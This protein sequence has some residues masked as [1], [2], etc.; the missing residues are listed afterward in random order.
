MLVCAALGPVCLLSNRSRT[1]D[2]A[3]I[4]GSKCIGPPNRSGRR[5]LDEKPPSPVRFWEQNRSGEAQACAARLRER[6]SNTL[7]ELRKRSRPGRLSHWML[8]C[9]PGCRGLKPRRLSKEGLSRAS[10]RPASPTSV[11]ATLTWT[12]TDDASCLKPGTTTA[13]S[14]PS[15]KFFGVR[16]SG[17]TD[18]Y[19]IPIGAFAAELAYRLTQTGV[20]Y[21]AEPIDYPAIAVGY[22]AQ[23]YGTA[24]TNSVT[25]EE[26]Q[27]ETALISFWHDCPGHKVILA[28]YSQGAHVGGISPMPSSR[29]TGS[30]SP[31]SRCSGIP[32][33]I[34]TRGRW[35]WAPTIT[36]SVSTCSRRPRG[37]SPGTCTG[38]SARCAPWEIRSAISPSRMR[39]SA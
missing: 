8:S 38:S 37:W 24:Y 34:R 26:K 5:S 39:T 11:T 32:G 7:P 9:G 3:R 19:G 6:T 23:E 30:W 22:A 28:G 13:A 10:P 33:S 36:T 20:S 25:A 14:C 17:E 4:P 18:A 12:G 2:R 29:V 35:M 15:V 27:L 16:G 21:G 1:C 31:L